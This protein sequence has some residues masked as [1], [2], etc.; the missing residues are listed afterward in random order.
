MNSG[1]TLGKLSVPLDN[2][3][4]IP[5][6]HHTH[7]LSLRYSNCFMVLLNQRAYYDD[8]SPDR[9]PPVEPGTSKTSG[10]THSLRS[11][12]TNL[13]SVGEVSTI[14]FSPTT[15]FDDRTKKGDIELGQISGGMKSHA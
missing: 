10:F 15:E 3:S 12:G 13:S 8:A 2:R 6:T 1:Y 7:T 4:H 14:L 9:G 11:G 5:S